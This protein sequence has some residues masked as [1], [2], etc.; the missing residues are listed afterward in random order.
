MAHA[1]VGPGRAG[2]PTPPARPGMIAWLLIAAGIIGACGPGR[3]SARAGNE[4]AREASPTPPAWADV[5]RFVDFYEPAL[6]AGGYNLV[7]YHYVPV[8]MDMNGAVVHSWDGVQ[9]VD[10]VRL[11]PSG[12]LAAIV[13]RGPFAVFDWTGRQ[14]LNFDPRDRKQFLHHDFTHLASGNWLLLVRDERAMVD[15]LLEID[16]QGREIW[17]WDPRDFIADDFSRSVMPFDVTH[18]NSVEEIPPNRWFDA[19]HEAFRPGNILISARNLNALYVIEKST[20]KVVWRYEE[21]L[22]YQHEARMVPVGLPG[23]GHIT[24]FN[25][26]YYNRFAYRRSS[27]VELDPVERRVVRRYHSD[28]FFSSVAGAEQVLPNGN[29]LVTSTESGRAFEVTRPGRIVWQWA[30]PS[31]PSRLARYAYDFCPQLAALGAPSERAVARRDP[32]RFVDHDLYSFALVH[33]LRAET[34]PGSSTQILDMQSACRTLRLPES[35]ILEIGYGVSHPEKCRE[36]GRPRAHFGVTI[37]GGDGNATETLLDRALELPA[38][39]SRPEPH[40]ETLK[41]ARYAG[42][43]VELCLAVTSEKG[44]DPAPCF[45]WE[46]PQIYSEAE[47]R[48]DEP[49][50]IQDPEIEDIQRRRLEALGYID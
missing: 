33:E 15:L 48:A 19:G 2:P 34:L 46:A 3:E 4:V 43:T 20:G 44:G 38:G 23:A 35:P 39:G 24:F 27:V 50:G 11:L 8:L 36:S 9:A 10:R 18:V 28:D 21:G 25:N 1:R 14:V 49:G 37:R 16:R 5:G 42:Q 13:L 31:K 41:P 12:H 17:R 32:A 47:T 29:L 7:L 40:R 45:V 30:P 22:D 26:G 6:S